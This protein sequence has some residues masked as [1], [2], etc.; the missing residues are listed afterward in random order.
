ME[1]VN[2]FRRLLLE[3]KKISK[4]THNIFVYRFTCPES[5]VSYHDHD[6]DGET[7]AGGRLAE[8]IRLMEV[9]N[10]ALGK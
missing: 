9:D 5:S 2:N 6:D 8:V 10:I 4:A 1:D 3:D 7:A